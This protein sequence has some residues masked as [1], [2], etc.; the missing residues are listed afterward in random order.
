MVRH[1]KQTLIDNHLKQPLMVFRRNAHRNRGYNVSLARTWQPAVDYGWPEISM[2]GNYLPY[3]REVSRSSS[4][5]SKKNVSG[6]CPI[7]LVLQLKLCRWGYTLF[8]P[9]SPYAP[10]LRHVASTLTRPMSAATAIPSWSM[11]LTRSSCYI[12]PPR[13]L[14]QS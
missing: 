2:C 6:L 8:S 5:W 9:S 4:A 13:C 14:F 10:A 11:K 1:S 3:P 12:T 7:C